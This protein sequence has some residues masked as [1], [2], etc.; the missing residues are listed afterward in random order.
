MRSPRPSIVGSVS[1][2]NQIPR[3]G[4]LGQSCRFRLVYSKPL[5]HVQDCVVVVGVVDIEDNE[6]QVW[7]QCEPTMLKI[8]YLVPR[9]V[10]PDARIECFV[11]PLSRRDGAS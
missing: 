9:I 4:V 1:V 7:V 8:E 3:I 2:L 11:M 6:D 5:P 10:T